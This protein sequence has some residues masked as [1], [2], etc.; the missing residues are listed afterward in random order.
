M[1]EENNLDIV[2]KVSNIVMP[3]ANRKLKNNNAGQK[4]FLRAA[5][6]MFMHYP[7]LCKAV[8]KIFAAG[9]K[10]LTVGKRDS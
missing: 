4:E 5:N 9:K 7:E 2:K 3:L 10:L 1:R 6:N 8:T